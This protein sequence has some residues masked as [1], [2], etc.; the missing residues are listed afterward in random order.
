[1]LLIFNAR[2]SY[3]KNLDKELQEAYA[4]LQ[5]YLSAVEDLATA[6]ERTRTPREL[7]DGAALFAIRIGRRE[8]H[9]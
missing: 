9:Y 8:I 5:I 3:R 6:K 4:A 7:H 2:V 1:M